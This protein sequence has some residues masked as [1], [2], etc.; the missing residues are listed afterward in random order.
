VSDAIKRFHF[1]QEIERELG[2]CQVTRAGGFVFLAGITA[3][4]E[5]GS[6]AHAGDLGGQLRKVYETAS[7]VLATQG[8]T[9][10]DVVDEVIHV[11]D[12]EQFMPH[13]ETRKGFFPSGRYPATIALEVRG[14]ALPE[15]LIEVK[16]VAYASS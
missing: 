12:M 6:V 2:Y 16:L 5:D 13:A 11:K 15:V 7:R 1:L 3:A 14:F 9:L 4:N 8:L 10:A